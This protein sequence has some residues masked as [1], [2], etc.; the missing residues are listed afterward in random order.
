M[1]SLVGYLGFYD[2]AFITDAHWTM[3]FFGDVLMGDLDAFYANSYS[4]IYY[5]YR[6][7]TPPSSC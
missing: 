4:L 5:V 7:A 3:G 6:H 1:V 2:R